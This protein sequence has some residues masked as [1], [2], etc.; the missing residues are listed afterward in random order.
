MTQEN[1]ELLLRDLCA[2]LP[3]GAIVNN[4]MTGDDD[5]LTYSLL[6]DCEAV[7]TDYPKPYLR[8][9]SSMTGE[10]KNELY[11]ICD[12][13]L[14]EWNKEM[15]SFNKWKIDAKC[16]SRRSEFYNSHHLDWNNLIEKGLA[17][18]AL[19]GMYN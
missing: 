13:Y 16:S 7:N 10:E 1:K 14:D 17:L 5:V 12:S 2:R 15:T 19:E 11:E 8:L 4:P 3:Y 6:E 9:M 18:E